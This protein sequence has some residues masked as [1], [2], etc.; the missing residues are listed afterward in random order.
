MPGGFLPA[1][2]IVVAALLLSFASFGLWT[3]ASKPP[4][5]SAAPAAARELLVTNGTVVTMDAARTVVER[6]A[7]AIEDGRILEVGLAAELE[8][9]HPDAERIDARG[10]IVLPGLINAHTHAA[11]VLFRGLADDLD[12]M[13]W[14]EG[15]I[16]PAEAK[17]VDEDFVRAGTRLACLE[18]LR[19]GTTTMVDLYYYEDA[20][21]EEVE[22]CGM[23]GV[24]AQ[25]VIGFPAPDFA[26]VEE[27]MVATRRFAERWR[28]HPRV[29]AA[30]AP[31]ALYTLT[32][33]QM[34]AVHS[35]AAE[36]DI[37]MV[38]HMAENRTEIARMIDRTGKRSIA[39]FDELGALDDRVLGAHV[40]EASA[41][42]IA[43]LAERGVGVAHCPQS[44]MKVGAGIAPVVAMITA[45]VAVGVGTDGAGSNNDL[46]LWEEIDTAAKLQKLATG[47]PKALDA[48][49][50]LAMATIEGARAIE[51]EDEIG[52]LEPG[53]RADLVVVTVDGVHQQPQRPMP[54]PYS[55]L[56]YATKASDVET[57]LVE[58]RVVVRDGE[59]LTL[60][61]AAVLAAAAEKRKPLEVLASQP[62]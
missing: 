12:L 22:R 57:V 43:L 30:I 15:H 41:E 40:V 52:S 13:D 35:L 18:M 19:G 58:G 16:F 49:Q 32:G 1:P 34:K 50:A 60:D 38:T 31:H 7:V 14:L 24:L 56:V 51:L 45:G 20:V 23:R 28:G 29:M 48:R 17:Y 59:V 10:G 21:A 5:E 62:R 42:E 37:P 2:R 61:A 46:D 44:N 36:L 8:A 6:G 11:M 9:R 39:V 3:C 54:N 33:E 53:K 26:T 25:T 55:L 27:A 4:A 47:D